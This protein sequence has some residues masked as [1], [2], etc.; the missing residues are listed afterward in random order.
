MCV[1]GFLENYKSSSDIQ[2]DR[3]VDCQIFFVLLDLLFQ[4]N[5]FVFDFFHLKH[6]FLARSDSEWWW[7]RNKRRIFLCLLLLDSFFFAIFLLIDFNKASSFVHFGKFRSSFYK[8]FDI[9]RVIDI[10]NL[11]SLT[12]PKVIEPLIDHIFKLIFC[13]IDRKVKSH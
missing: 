1:S 9:V 3:S 8:L 5:D 2:I 11:K 10:D 6:Y 4:V 13:L 12:L 7:G